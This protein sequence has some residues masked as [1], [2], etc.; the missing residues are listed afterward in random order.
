MQLFLRS[1][2][3]REL[4]IGLFEN[5]ELL[6]CSTVDIGPEE[7]L[8]HV[9]DVLKKHGKTLG[10]ID[11][12]YVVT[13]PGSFTASRVS[14]TIANTIAFT[15]EIPVYAIENLQKKTIAEL[16]KTLKDLDLKEQQWAQPFYD[17]PPMITQAKSS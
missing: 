2:D 17:R 7:H 8:K 12:V 9:D 1:Q 13:G 3:I 5:E 15:Q 16:C 10:D 14:I 11:G 6:F 4:E